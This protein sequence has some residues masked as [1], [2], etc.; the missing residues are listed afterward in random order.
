[1]TTNTQDAS[2]VGVPS[3]GVPAVAAE[4]ATP[5]VE[6]STPP[7]VLLRGHPEYKQYVQQLGTEFKDAT[8]HG[9]SHI[10][11]YQ[12]N[13]GQYLS[14]SLPRRGLV[15]VHGLGTG[16]TMTA[17][18]VA[19]HNPSRRAW[20][21][22]K[23]GLS[24]H[25]QLKRALAVVDAQPASSKAIIRAY[26]ELRRAPFIQDILKEDDEGNLV[27]DQRL[28]HDTQPPLSK[29]ELYTKRIRD[30]HEF[31][32]FA[33]YNG[34]ASMLRRLFNV[35]S[36]NTVR[37]TRELLWDALAGR[38]PNPLD[39]HV[40]IVDEAHN[41]AEGALNTAKTGATSGHWTST[42][43]NSAA[44]YTLLLYARDCKIALLT[45]TPIVNRSFSIG[46]L[47]N[48]VAGYTRCIPV[49]WDSTRSRSRRTIADTLG[50]WLTN[51]DHG[52]R[53]AVQQDYT[54][55][56]RGLVYMAPTNFRFRT[57][58]MPFEVLY[59]PT[60]PQSV[61]SEQVLKDACANAG[62]VVRDA[63]YTSLP[64][65]NPIHVNSDGRFVFVENAFHQFRQLY[66]PSRT[67][68]DATTRFA[69]MA[70]GLISVY[71]TMSTMA[72]L[73]YYDACMNTK[74][75]V[76]T[77]PVAFFQHMIRV[78]R[79]GYVHAAQSESMRT[80]KGGDTA[81][82]AYVNTNITT[83]A[84]LAH[85]SLSGT[86]VAPNMFKFEPQSRS[87]Y[88]RQ[89]SVKYYNL[90]CNLLGPDG[91]VRGKSIIYS[92]YKD[93]G[94]I[95]TI[96]RLLEHNGFRKW[97]GRK[98]LRRFAIYSGDVPQVSTTE[99]TRTDVL[100]AFDNDQ[101]S[102]LLMT[103]AGAE[104]INTSNVTQ[105]HV[106]EPF[107]HNV[108]L[109]QVIGRARRA[110]SH[111][112]GSVID[113]FVYVATL[114][115]TEL[116]TTDQQMWNIAIRKKQES[117]AIMKYGISRV[118]IEAVAD[119]TIVFRRRLSTV[120]AF[121]R[122]QHRQEC[123][124]EIQLLLKTAR[125]IRTT[126][127][128]NRV[129]RRALGVR[130]TSSVRFA[131]GG[132][133]GRIRAFDRIRDISNLDGLVHSNHR[134]DA[135]SSWLFPVV[136]A[137]VRIGMSPTTKQS[138]GGVHALY[139]NQYGRLGVSRETTL[140]R[141]IQITQRSFGDTFGVSSSKTSRFKAESPNMV[142]RQS[143]LH[144]LYENPA[145]PTTTD[146][147]L[148][149]LV[150][151]KST[152]AIDIRYPM[153]VMIRVHSSPGL[154]ENILRNSTST[155]E[156]EIWGV[157]GSFR[158]GPRYQHTL[159]EYA[160]RG[161]SQCVRCGDMTTLMPCGL[162]TQYYE[163]ARQCKLNMPDSMF[164]Q[165]LMNIKKS[166]IYPPTRSGVPAEL[167]GK[168]MTPIEYRKLK[169]ASHIR[170]NAVARYVGHVTWYENVVER[171]SDK[172]IATSSGATNM[173]ILSS[174][175]SSVDVWSRLSP[176][177]RDATIDV[178]TR[179]HA[180]PASRATR[181]ANQV[182]RQYR[183]SVHMLHSSNPVYESVLFIE[184]ARADAAIVE[185]YRELT[186]KGRHTIYD[187]DPPQTT[188]YR[189]SEISTLCYGH[190]PTVDRQLKHDLYV[191]DADED[192]IALQ[193]EAANLAFQ[194]RDDDPT[195]DDAAFQQRRDA[196]YRWCAQYV[197]AT[198][199]DIPRNDAV[200]VRTQY[201]IR[202]ATWA[203]DTLLRYQSNGEDLQNTYPPWAQQQDY[204]RFKEL[205]H[206]LNLPPK[207]RL[208]AVIEDATTFSD[209]TIQE[210]R[211]DAV[212]LIATYRQGDTSVFKA[213]EKLLHR[214]LTHMDQTFMS[215]DILD[216]PPMTPSVIEN[217]SMSSKPLPV[218]YDRPCL[219]CMSRSKKTQQSDATTK[220]R[221]PGW[222][223]TTRAKID[224][225][226]V[227]EDESYLRSFARDIV[228][229]IRVFTNMYYERR[230]HTADDDDD[231]YP[232]TLDTDTST[233][234]M[235]DESEDM[236]EES[237]DTYEKT[238]STYL[239]S[240]DI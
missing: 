104:G 90:L 155:P 189:K 148:C 100:T 199:R 221:I 4:V 117:D 55:G 41:I 26:Q 24:G 101:F 177:A 200:R 86:N 110:T 208:D 113:V 173:S 152:S 95:H 135:V 28:R 183:T 25:N 163:P 77:T 63:Q 230:R 143:I 27:G 109:E 132:A 164:K 61:S 84:A 68:S 162:N 23:A 161:T 60:P 118:S 201:I 154:A 7:T 153:Y 185:R 107:W 48:M 181:I 193:L 219:S 57:R 122:D 171:S 47:C 141:L 87:S 136:R 197:T 18:R 151:Q 66:E 212:N 38:I 156:Y 97:T 175:V 42:P 73:R 130:H 6:S 138:F 111:K 53:I 29:T 232:S 231:V 206:A 188:Q 169:S 43:G 39:G 106:M 85:A 40:V 134:Y 218:R 72:T 16:K 79:G 75:K 174:H 137:R 102:V 179:I 222:S 198:L 91:R 178:T 64:F 209:T 237:G 225:P 92:R 37:P 51:Q 11:K 227:S 235:H 190:F 116:T 223:V 88:L 112:K 195:T 96:Q 45:A 31:Y 157:R 99:P 240:E 184:R 54:Q 202:R 1:M 194:R 228:R 2:A 133:G 30:I 114:R 89:Y 236:D 70:M 5:A 124:A 217:L 170:M 159:D 214:V 94:G 120:L 205:L 83:R 9:P 33:H 34:G 139:L 71:D 220:E 105:V 59:S 14:E 187:A 224:T 182:L 191:E 22:T 144:T 129:R 150:P 142:S 239:Q 13:V 128:Y 176:T 203:R 207:L 172:R 58:T 20:V 234:D 126:T 158:S 44:L 215:E 123:R 10:F 140:R 32:R 160:G 165:L 119:N 67:D 78:Q 238:L 76:S 216:V 147:P 213:R 69:E 17:I 12:D 62:L 192:R 149:I 49:R 204:V 166:T 80:R 168:R 121:R 81:S 74:P 186:R 115:M 93:H 19:Q 56:A 125:S 131:P 211:A 146:G 82:A 180:N 8:R 196:L 65:P 210:L 229:D 21:I 35:D 145:D 50:S 98:A 233:L 226:L 3:V 103:S 127:D 36:T 15:V 167:A 52:M 46:M 108:R